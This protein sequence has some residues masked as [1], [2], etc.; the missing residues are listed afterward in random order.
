RS[1]RTSRGGGVLLLV[2]YALL[3]VVF[4]LSGDR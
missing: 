3:A 1:G 2:A 4:Y